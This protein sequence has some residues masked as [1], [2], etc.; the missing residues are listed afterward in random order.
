MKKKTAKQHVEDILRDYE[1]ARGDD[2]ALCLLYWRLVDGIDFR[3]F[4]VGFM[5][6]ATMPESITRARRLIQEEGKYRPSEEIIE[7]R[8][9]RERSMRGSVVKHREVI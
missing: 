8:R 6:K 7:R 4:A 3:N 2:K 9:D 1:V 5:D